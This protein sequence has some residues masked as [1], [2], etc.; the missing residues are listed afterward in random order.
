LETAHTRSRIPEE[1]AN[2]AVSFDALNSA[3]RPLGSRASPEIAS[4]SDPVGTMSRMAVPD[5]LADAR[6]FGKVRLL[7]D[8]FIH[9]F[10]LV[11]MLAE[12]R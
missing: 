4:I 7:V 10:R 6:E 8:Q 12:A 1:R 5:G 9:A 3:V 11:R 2:S